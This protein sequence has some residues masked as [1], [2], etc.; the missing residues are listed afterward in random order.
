[1]E[2]AP[3]PLV[4]QESQEDKE[5]NMSAEGGPR[6]KNGLEKQ[7][8]WEEVLKNFEQ[9][10]D[11]LGLPIE[12]SIKETVV[13]LNV[14]EIPTGSSCG[15]HIEKDRLSFPYV[16]GEAPGEPQYRYQG[17]D[18]IIESLITKYKLS[19]RRE[20]F[21][22]GKIEDE[23][24]NLTDNLEETEEYK[25]WYL[26]NEPLIQ[27]ITQ[28]I[29]EFNTTSSSGRICLAPIYPGYRIEAHDRK[30]EFVEDMQK[31]KEIQLAQ[32]EFKAFTDFLKQRFFAKESE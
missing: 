4:N 15:G 12:E 31:E 6:I 30:K 11:G 32:K 18:K 5:S 29:E 27:Q 21:D 2:F 14:N 13:S 23:Y 16:S 26:K 1:M 8:K 9:V 17:E 24:Y 10:T 28:L 20:I 19:D 22:D 3:K 25:E 7:K